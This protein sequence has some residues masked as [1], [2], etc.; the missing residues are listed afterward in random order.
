MAGQQMSNEFALSV[1]CNGPND[2]LY[3]EAPREDLC[4]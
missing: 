2:I 4:Q 3:F 1:L